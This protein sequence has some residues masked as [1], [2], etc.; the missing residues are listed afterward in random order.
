MRNRRYYCVSV[1]PADRL[2]TNESYLADAIREATGD[3][4]SNY[5][6]NMRLQY[7]LELLNNQLN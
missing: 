3:T 4:Y 5:I 2:G 6:T 7:S 1:M